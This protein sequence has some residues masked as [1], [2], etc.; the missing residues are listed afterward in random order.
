MAMLSIP[1]PGTTQA[2]VSPLLCS[3]FGSL[4]GER[5]PVTSTGTAEGHGAVTV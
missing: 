3:K 1:S 2:T 4:R 5:D